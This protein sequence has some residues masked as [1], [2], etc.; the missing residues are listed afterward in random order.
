VIETKSI[1]FTD[2]CAAFLLIA[3]VAFRFIRACSSLPGEQV[4]D[5][6]FGQRF[7]GYRT[8]IN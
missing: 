7:I 4:F 1:R 5:H 6:C 2:Q 8:R 3:Y